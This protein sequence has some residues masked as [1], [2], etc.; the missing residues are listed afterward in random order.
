MT[1]G[2][3]GGAVSGGNGND[4]LIISGGSID[5]FVAGNDGLDVIIISG[6]T[7]TGD[8][9]AEDVTLNGGTI[10]GD[11][12]GISADT[13]TIEDTTGTL[14][15][16]N[17]VVFSG[18]DANATIT[19]TDLAEGGTETQNFQ[20]FDTVALDTSTL[21]FGPGTVDIAL[22]T[23]ADGSTLYVDGPTNMAG[24]LVVTNSTVSM[25][26]GA[27]DDVFTLGG[28]TLYS[29][30]IG[31]DLDQQALQ[32]D[33]IIANAFAATGTNTIQVNLL[34]TPEFAGVTDIPVLIATNDPVT[35]VF[36]ITGI[37]GTVSSLFTFEVVQGADGGLVIRAT[38]GNFGLAAL[39]PS[40]VNSAATDLAL[41]TIAGVT[42]DA[43]D[44]DLGL[45]NG[46]QRAQLSPTFGVFASGQLAAVDHDGFNITAGDITGVGPGSTRM[47]SLPPSALISMPPSISSST[48]GTA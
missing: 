40:A 41:D 16:R 48:T 27:A 5:G 28:I 38:P 7:I 45:G 17:G 35:G 13:L 24:N 47:T 36:Q 12:T 26:D 33:Q 1:G 9:S 32:A 34:G 3:L 29:A 30:T 11:I 39:P 23:L 19:N 46:G 2:T 20:G 42:K 10:G 37:P 25:I 21:G 15:L 14:D 22:L 8:V 6:G 43:M 18:D 4:I 44:F 31:I